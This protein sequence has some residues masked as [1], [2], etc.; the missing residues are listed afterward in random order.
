MRKLTVFNSVTLDGVMQAPGRPDEDRRDGFTHGGWALAYNDEVM[1]KTVAERMAD[2]GPLLLGRRTYEDFFSFWPRQTGNPFSEVL[3]NTLKYVASTTL[4]EPLGW[5]NS[6][7]LS[8]DA[9]D[10]VAELK[11]QP[12]PGL[13]VLGS[14]ELVQALRR[15]ELI[16]EYLLLIHPLVLGSGRRLFPD[17]GPPAS[18]RLVDAKPTTTGVI[19]ATYQPAGGVQDKEEQP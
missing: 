11:G 18:L 17:G 8:G 14:G 4:A 9:A 7:L 3:D 15:R 19:I 1:A 16:D 12:G 10:A 2:P 13:T 5:R 6:E